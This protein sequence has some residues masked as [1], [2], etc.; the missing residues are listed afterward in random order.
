MV[1]TGR[2]HCRSPPGQAP[3][4]RKTSSATGHKRNPGTFTVPILQTQKWARLQP[5]G[6]GS[7]DRQAAAQKGEFM[8]SL[9]SNCS[10]CR[11]W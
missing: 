10:F 8:P 5:Q 6:R 7:Q 2:G 11:F 4:V 1:M 3:E 9:V